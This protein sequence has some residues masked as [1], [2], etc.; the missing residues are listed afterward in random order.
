MNGYLSGKTVYLCGPIAGVS[1]EDSSSWREYIKP[2][3]N[4]FNLNILDPL[5]KDKEGLGESAEDRQ[6]FRNLIMQEKWEEHK[7][8][9]WPVARWDLRSVDKSDFIIVN[10]DDPTHA[11]VGT[12]H[13]V[14]MASH[15][16][17]KPVL[18]KYNRNHLDKF[19]FW[20]PVLVKSYHMFAEWNDMFVYLNKINDGHLDSSH[21]TL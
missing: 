11:T 3:L 18:L 14:V 6:K 10:Y 20:V 4:K 17:K 8:L 1:Q 12:W 7:K 2:T 13:E 16:E 21:W 5:K 15:I 19:N 9:F